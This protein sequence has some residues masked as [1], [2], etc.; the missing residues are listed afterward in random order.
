MSANDPKP[1]WRLHRSSRLIRFRALWERQL[2]R[3]T[4]MLRASYGSSGKRLH[5]HVIPQEVNWGMGRFTNKIVVTGGT[6]GIG[7]AAARQF[8]K[9]GAEVVVT[10]RS[11]RSADD[12][13]NE[14]GANGVAITAD[15]TRELRTQA[16]QERASADRRSSTRHRHHARRTHGQASSHAG[17]VF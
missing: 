13:Q 8:I 15:V 2:I 17:R 14:L 12:A 9:E 11:R 6:S 5:F 16:R 1:T 3:K 10:G 4:G 7:L